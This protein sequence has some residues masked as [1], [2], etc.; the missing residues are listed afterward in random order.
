MPGASLDVAGQ[1]WFHTAAAGQPVLTSPVR[2]GDHIQWIIAQ[3]VPGTDGHP[4]SVLIG[5]LNPT[6]LGGLLNP[7]LDKGSDVVAVDAQHHLIYSHQD[8][9][10]ATNDTALLAAGAL[11]H[12]RGQRRHPQGGQHRPTRHRPVHR[13]RRQ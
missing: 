12:H 7:E 9:G 1:A 5:K 10:K 13:P 2:Q 4:R 3:P 6:A 8:M 11:Q